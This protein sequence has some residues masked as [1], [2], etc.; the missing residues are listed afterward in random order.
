MIF[1][2]ASGPVNNCSQR[3]PPKLQGEQRRQRRIRSKTRQEASKVIVTKTRQI[4]KDSFTASKAARAPPASQTWS[5]SQSRPHHASQQS[6][7]L[8]S[9]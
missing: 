8:L 5:Q 6:G 4:A 7:D 3:R 9:L 2:I 1:A